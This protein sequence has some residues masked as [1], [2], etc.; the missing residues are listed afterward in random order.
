MCQIAVK[1]TR[2]QILTCKEEDGVLGKFQHS[3]ILFLCSMLIN[4]ILF[5]NMC[6]QPMSSLRKITSKCYLAKN[7]HHSFDEKQLNSINLP[8]GKSE[9]YPTGCRMAVVPYVIF[10]E[11]R[12]KRNMVRRYVGVLKK[13]YVYITITTI[14]KS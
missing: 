9:D 4:F 5:Q 2:C 6:Q 14:P 1:R 13:Q 11:S 12:Q 3:H 7:S 10:K 8:S